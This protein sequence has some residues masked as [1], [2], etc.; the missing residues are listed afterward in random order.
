MKK[1][2]FFIGLLNIAMLHAQSDVTVTLVIAPPYSPYLSDYTEFGGQNILQLTNTTSATLQLKLVGQIEGLDNGIQVSTDVGY[3]PVAPVTLAPFQTLFVTGATQSMDFLDANHITTNLTS[4]QEYSLF[5]SGILPEG[6]YTICIRALDYNTGTPLS[7][8]APSGCTTITIAYPTPPILINP[9]CSTAINMN[10]PVFTWTP[11]ISSGSFF[12]YD[13]YVMELLEGQIP[14][15]AMYLAIETGLGN[16]VVIHNLATTTYNYKPFDVPLV[17]GKTYIWCVVARDANNL[18]QIVNDGRSEVCMF[19]YE[20]P[21]VPPLV[22]EVEQDLLTE[23]IFSLNNSSV[24]GQLMYRFYGNEEFGMPPAPVYN[25]TLTVY[26]IP[27]SAEEL[28]LMQPQNDNTDGNSGNGYQMSGTGLFDDFFVSEVSTALG[29]IGGKIDIDPGVKYLYQN[30]LNSGGAAPLR[31]TSVSIYLEY[32]AVVRNIAGEEYYFPVI[33]GAELYFNATAVN[34]H[35]NPID[36]QLAYA[37]SQAGLNVDDAMALRPLGSELLGTATTDENGNFTF[38]FDMTENTGLLQAGPLTLLTWYFN[39]PEIPNEEHEWVNPLDE[40]SNPWD[41]LLNPVDELM[42]DPYD[43]LFGGNMFMQDNGGWNASGSGTEGFTTDFNFGNTFNNLFNSNGLNQN[44]NQNFNQFGPGPAPFD[45]PVLSAWDL[46]TYQNYTVTNLFKVLRIKVNDPKYVSPDVLIFVQPGDHV[47]LPPVTTFVNSYDAHITFIAGGKESDDP[48]LAPGVPMSNVN[49]RIGHLKSWWDTRP[50][51]FPAGE[52]MDINPD[53]FFSVDPGTPYFYSWNQDEDKPGQLRLTSELPTTASGKAI[54][55]R[56]VGNINYTN[57]VFYFEAQNALTGTYNYTGSWGSFWKTVYLPPT[58]NEAVHSWN[59]R[60]DTIEKEVKL[61]PLD[62]EL[63]LRTVTVSN[64]ETAPLEGVDVYML[65]YNKAGST[66]TYTG[67]DLG[68]TDAEGYQRFTNIDMIYGPSGLENPYRRVMLNKWGYAIKYLPVNVSTPT[69]DY[70]YLQP[71]K[72]GQRLDLGEVVMTGNAGVYGYVKDDLDK[73][74]AALVRIGDGPWYMTGMTMDDTNYDSPVISSVPVEHPPV[75]FSLPLGD[76]YSSIDFFNSGDYMTSDDILSDIQ[77]VDLSGMGTQ[78]NDG[79]FQIVDQMP[80]FGWADN[81]IL[82]NM[83]DMKSKFTINTGGTG[84][85]TRVIIVPMSDQYMADTFY[86]NVPA[87]V[88]DH[89]LGTFVVFE[90]A[91]RV[92][93]QVKGDNGNGLFGPLP[94]IGASVEV[95]DYGGVTGQ[96]GFAWFRFTTPDSYFRMYMQ[97]NGYVPFENYEYIP[98]SKSYQIKTYTLEQGMTVTGQ[99]INAVTGAGIENARVF[100]PTGTTLYGLTDVET[101]TDANGFYTLQGVPREVIDIHAAVSSSDPSYIGNTYHVYFP[102]PA[103]S[104]A[105]IALQPI[106]SMDLGNLYGFPIEIDSYLAQM[107]GHAIISGAFVDVPSNANFSMLDENTRIRFVN[108][109]VA[110]DGPPGAGGLP[111][112]V[113]VAG[114]VNTLELV[115]RVRVHEA[116][117]ADMFSH[118]TGW[119]PTIAVQPADEGE[120]T[121]KGK[122]NMDLESFKFSYDYSGSF[123]LG[124]TSSSATVNAFLADPAASPERSY[125][126]MNL[127]YGVPTDISFTIHDFDAKA[128]RTRSK[129]S[130]DSVLIATLLYPDLPLASDV[131]V[132]AG[133]ISVT[134]TSIVIGNPGEEISFGL[135]D[136]TVESD[137]GWSYSIPLGGIVMPSASIQTQLV[138]IPISNLILRPTELIMEAGNVNLDDLMVGGNVTKLYQYTGSEAVF[139]FDPACSWDLGPHWRFSLY[140]ENDGPSSYIKGLPG[141]VSTQHIDFGSFTLYSNNST[142]IQPITQVLPFHNISTIS[143]QNISSGVD[144]L[145]IAGAFF[146]DIPDM[147]T[148]TIILEYTKPSY[149]I[150]RKV[151]SLDIGL[152]NPGKVY[153]DGYL[154]TEYYT[155]SDN[156]FEANGELIFEDDNLNDNNKIEL[157]GKLVK[158]LTGTVLSIPKLQNN[159]TDAA[160]QYIQMDGGYQS[161][162][163]VLQGEQKVVGGAWNTMWF[164]ADLVGVEGMGNDK[165]LK[166]LVSGAV[167]ADSDPSNKLEIEDIQTPFGG[168]TL[169]F[170]WQKGSFLGS[171]TISVPIVIYSFQLNSGLFEL[172]V[173]GTG[174][175]FDVIGNVSLPGLEWL[176]VN[177][178][179]LTGYYEELPDAVIDR[180]ANIMYLADVPDYLINDGIGGIYF[181]AN[182][183]PSI[184]NWSASIDLLVFAVGMGVNAG[185][186]MNFLLNFGPT[187]VMMLEAA[188]YAKAWAGV[189]VLICSLCIG[190]MAQFIVDG[191]LQLTPTVE[192][193]L[194]ACASFTMFGDF[195]GYSMEETI[196]CDVEYSTSSGF[197]FDMQWSPCGGTANKLN[198]SC[199]F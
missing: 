183:A 148:P 72:K 155:I 115:T 1:V 3:Q 151:K 80:E 191:T 142:Y 165:T 184:A 102:G 21:Y 161:K 163:K 66:Y 67:F 181:N 111:T 51:N 52:G 95:G 129:L 12:F 6:M 143:I 34:A 87:N 68:E 187:T 190:A 40:V 23:T 121:I 123:Y 188:A 179:C 13:L 20:E 45:P 91:H 170:D 44:F 47:T 140:G 172:Y 36:P 104:H 14:E 131:E 113:A 145:E 189:D 175:Y 119:F 135:E 27:K 199:D 15:D 152:Q 75:Y 76:L 173:D 7:A 150:V 41:A 110:P 114:E 98:I 158:D 159:N 69:A 97:A 63:L 9:I 62:P 176:D 133:T 79:G 112:A 92:K 73:P 60:P 182:V 109:E 10:L 33:P 153:F 171:L 137:G 4:D 149:A 29:L 185:A 25:P 86:V 38:N 46:L 141:F 146:L 58:M 101:Y 39:P 167:E 93:V 193:D 100:V 61:E 105:N 54:F 124:E 78:Y 197:D 116:F 18:I 28:A 56:L 77:V 11:V 19:T 186:D 30:T 144:G 160:Y 107:N 168:L 154:G 96:D 178:G 48:L 132:D 177:V 196:G 125:Y 139:N 53:E 138:D 81:G 59:F 192:A 83:L 108:I 164:E 16:P 198:T 118:K 5:T 122:V 94:L 120:G 43:A 50:N 180:H 147:T 71:A 22:E 32:V 55:S 24:T 8:D 127:K 128:D 174:F 37:A 90:K 26:D 70:H 2:L 134:P 157:K 42:N 84:S 169:V 194:G 85:N 117:V 65:E 88:S 64:I 35:G 126:L 103:I 156:Y 99:V 31:N 166:Y 82:D 162:L 195:C 17:A 89:N 57:S 74:V 130:N 136:W 49:V 106:G